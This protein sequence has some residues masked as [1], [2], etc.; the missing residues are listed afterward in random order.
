MHPESGA[1]GGL[2]KGG[3]HAADHG[4]NDLGAVFI[5]RGEVQEETALFFLHRLPNH[6]GN[7]I[8]VFYGD[9][10]LISIVVLQGS[11]G[12][13]EVPVPVMADSGQLV[14]HVE[15]GVAPHPLVGVDV[16]VIPVAF[17]L[18]QIPGV[19]ALCV[20]DHHTG[21]VQHLHEQAEGC[22]ISHADRVVVFQGS[23]RVVAVSGGLR[24]DL[25]G[26]GVIAQ[27]LGHPII[28]RFFLLIGRHIFCDD[29][30][31]HSGG[32]FQGLLVLCA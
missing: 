8:D 18:N 6:G 4:L 12:G 7:L 25:K 10:I 23:V 5:Q 31:Q 22:G 20:V 11:G 19:V 3:F 9:S 14:I 17:D 16:H 24:D 15:I 32:Q 21:N 27:F 26:A 28:Y 29:F 2:C 30:F 1:L 13:E